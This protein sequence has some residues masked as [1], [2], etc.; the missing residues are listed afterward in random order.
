LEVQ[1]ADLDNKDEREGTS[2]KG[3]GWE[4]TIMNVP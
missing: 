1:E 4:T 3:E 2:L